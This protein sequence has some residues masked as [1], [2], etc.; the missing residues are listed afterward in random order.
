MKIELEIPDAL[1]SRLLRIAINTK[2]PGATQTII[3]TNLIKKA[4]AV[5]E[6]LSQLSNEAGEVSIRDYGTNKMEKFSLHFNE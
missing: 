6:T 2:T 4:L 1:A 5:T 3:L